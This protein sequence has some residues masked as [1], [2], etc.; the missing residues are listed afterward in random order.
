MP[1][2]SV[3]TMWDMFLF[4]LV[5]ED[6][7][8]KSHDYFW[9]SAPEVHFEGGSRALE[10]FFKKIGKIEKHLERQRKN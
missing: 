8:V 7:F 1:S 2:F 5:P 3:E 4:S 6:R 10:I 9:K